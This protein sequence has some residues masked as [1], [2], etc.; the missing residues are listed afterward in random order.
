MPN[1]RYE[2]GKQCLTC[3]FNITFK[4]YFSMCISVCYIFFL[5]SLI[6]K[7]N[8]ELP[9]YQKKIDAELS[10]Y[11]KKINT[12]LSTYQKKP[13]ENYSFSTYLRSEKS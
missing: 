6:T 1:F 7:L 12:E 4:A 3:K 8:T 10:K 13:C 5:D 9:A 11:Q 2:K